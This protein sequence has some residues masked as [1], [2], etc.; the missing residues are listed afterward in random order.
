MLRRV[1]LIKVLADR[2]IVLLLV[3]NLLEFSAA[4]LVLI[5]K[6]LLNQLFFVLHLLRNY[7]RTSL[8]DS[9]RQLLAFVHFGGEKVVVKSVFRLFLCHFVA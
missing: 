6:A 2:G 9:L 1:D 5:D 8:I 3:I 7:V 4:S